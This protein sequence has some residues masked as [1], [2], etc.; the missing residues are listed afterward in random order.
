MKNPGYLVSAVQRGCDLL[1]SFR[2]EGE[3]LRLKDLAS[4]TGL[5]QSTAFRILYTLHQSGLIERVGYKAY[6]SRIKPCQRSRYRLGYAHLA[7]D[8]GFVQEWTDSIVRA[9]EKE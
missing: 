3:V 5:S 7:R 1:A 8:S 6:R 9:A 4:R 2:F